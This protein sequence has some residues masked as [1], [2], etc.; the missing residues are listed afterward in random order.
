MAPFKEK[1]FSELL[2]EK[3]NV[4]L[5]EPHIFSVL[6]DNQTPRTYDTRFGYIYDWVACN[7][8]YNRL[9][10]GYSISIF[11]SIAHDA[12]RSSNSGN[13]L[14]IGCGSLAFTAK[15]YIQYSERPVVL[16]DHSLN[17]LRI[18]KSRLIRF[19]GAVPENI[20]LLHADALKL[21]FRK[22]SF[23]TIISE[24]LLHCLDNTRILLEKLKVIIPDDGKMYF[25]TLVK[26]NRFADRYLE[27]L[28]NGGKLIS[29]NLVDHQTIFHQL[30]LPVK[31]D[32]YGNL[33]SIY[34]E[35]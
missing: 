35:D 22:K 26:A 17:M 24:N 10:W 23:Q 19:N 20:V 5:I 12:I 9:I 31:Y 21:P 4:R 29:R 25:T 2:S 16:V 28:A 33:A 15:V 6:P 32:I 1:D 3:S 14:D 8:V 7:P 27:A 34:I 18:A 30:G 13:V 11:A